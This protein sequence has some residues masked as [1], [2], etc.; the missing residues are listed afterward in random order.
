M[1][2]V[3][4]TP[5]CT[6]SGLHTDNSAARPRTRSNISG[7]VS[8]HRAKHAVPIRTTACHPPIHPDDDEPPPPRSPRAALSPPIQSVHAHNI[9][10][11]RRHSAHDKANRLQTRRHAATRLPVQRHVLARQTRSAGEVELLAQLVVLQRLGGWGVAGVD[12]GCG[13]DGRREGGWKRR[14]GD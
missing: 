8:F 5:G 6:R 11:H 14:G 13:W 4:Q 10:P 12:Q 2:Y 9:P 7:K 1:R 3:I